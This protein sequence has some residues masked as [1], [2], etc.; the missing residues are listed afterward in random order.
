MVFKQKIDSCLV[1][2]CLR[3]NII[4]KIKKNYIQ[5]ELVGS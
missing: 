5:G 4:L 3:F 2:K 1:E